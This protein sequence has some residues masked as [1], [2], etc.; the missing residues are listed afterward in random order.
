MAQR[1]DSFRGHAC[2]GTK[3][4]GSLSGSP[5]KQAEGGAEPP[6]GGFHGLSRGI[7]LLTL[8]AGKRFS[9]KCQV[10]RIW[11]EVNIRVLL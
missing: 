4:P 6:L 8:A 1:P 10:A 11:L 2:R 9:Q 7:D 5:L 3:V